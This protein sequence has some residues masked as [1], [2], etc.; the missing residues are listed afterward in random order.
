MPTVTPP[1]NQ[2]IA[3]PATETAGEVHLEVVNQLGGAVTAVAVQDNL[4]Y[5]G[6][7]SRLAV[8]DVSDPTQPQVISWSG[9]LPD[10]V[11]QIILR[12]GLA[13]VALGESGLWVFDISNPT[14]LTLLGQVQTTTPARQFLLQDDLAYVIDSSSPREPG[15]IL[16]VVDVVDPMK[17]LEISTFSLPS[18]ATKLVMVDDYLYISIYPYH[19]DYEDTLWVVDVSDADSLQLV[20]AVP[21]LAGSDMISFDG[22]LML[23]KAQTNWLTIINTD[24]PRHPTGTSLNSPSGFIGVKTIQLNENIIYVATT[25]SDAG[26]CAASVYAFDIADINNINELDGLGAVDCGIPQIAIANSYLYMATNS[27]LSIV[28]ISN[29]A[30][31]ILLGK[32]PTVLPVNQ[33]AIGEDLYTIG[34]QGNG[35]KVFGFNL[36]DPAN[37]HLVGEYED[38]YLVNDF[39]VDGSHIYVATYWAGI[40]QID[41]TDPTN[42]HETAVTNPEYHVENSNNLVLSAERLYASLNYN[43]GT[44]DPVTLEWIGGDTIEGYGNYGSFVVDNH[45]L[46][47]WVSTSEGDGLRAFDM[48]D[49]NQPIQIGFLPGESTSSNKELFV[50]QGYLYVLSDCDFRPENL[51]QGTALSIIDVTDPTAMRFVTTLTIADTI[52]TLSLYNNMV[53]L[54]G[55]DLWLMDV[56]DP[57]HPLITGSLQ[58]PGNAQDAVMHDGLI[59]VADGA[60]G[61]LVLRPLP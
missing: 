54:T 12:D 4:A 8:A 24:D 26:S 27:G 55:G 31:M 42:P 21:E 29:P 1:M 57:T 46:W 22:G 48:T 16:S 25:F 9:I 32:L 40:A 14:T 36:D 43:L 38:D 61:L 51:C 15:Q 34:R 28:D 7:G 39:A 2:V 5:L 37:P 52:R 60:G 50:N 45:T 33:L 20:T 35:F 49:P 6:I 58:T 19:A 53:L 59:Y 18:R 44:F 47:T 3:A 23:P 41:M 17:P 56:S 30:S 13:Y 10:I 11:E